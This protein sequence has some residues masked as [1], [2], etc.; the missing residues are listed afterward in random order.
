[1]RHT[2]YILLLMLLLLWV[3]P[4]YATTNVGTAG[5]Q[6]LKIGPGARVDSLGGAFSALANDVTSIYWNPAGISQLEKTSLVR[7][8]Y[9]LARRCPLQLF[10]LCYPNRKYWHLGRKRHIPQRPRYRDHH[11]GKA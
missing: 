2:T 6:F 10:S 3:V 5:A 7:H 4:G 11:V 1:M 8:P 9:S